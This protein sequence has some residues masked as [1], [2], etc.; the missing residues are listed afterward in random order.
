MG[1]ED[2]KLKD[3]KDKNYIFQSI[4]REIMETILDTAKGIWD[5]M[6]QKRK[7]TTKVKKEKLQSLR[8]EFE[9]LG[10]REGESISEYFARTLVIVNKMKLQGNNMN[11]T[12]VVEKVMRSL[13]QGFNYVVCSIEESDDIT[14]LSI[15][16]FQ[17]KLLVHESIMLWQGV[18]EEDQALK[19]TGM[20]RGKGRGRGYRGG[21]DR[22]RQAQSKE[23]IECYH[24]C[25]M[26]HYQ[27]ECPS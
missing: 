21:R 16:D 18:K 10:M 4:D 25:K 22:G 9:L 6:K 3:L 13:P 1:V 7:G 15:N 14:T 5:S 26:K 11:Q 19:V 17:G 2:A 12:T 27:Y 24:Y 23:L 8:R 20:A